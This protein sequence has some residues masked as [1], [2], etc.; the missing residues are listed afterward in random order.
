MLG[1]A[2]ISVVHAVGPDIGVRKHSRTPSASAA[3]AFV[4]GSNGQMIGMEGGNDSIRRHTQKLD[5]LQA[6]NDT[7]TISFGSESKT[8]DYE[9]HVGLACAHAEGRSHSG[10]TLSKCKS[11]C[12]KN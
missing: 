7:A 12:T 4:V 1:V 3:D 2:I 8:I 11:R 6:F 10:L 5:D 9:I